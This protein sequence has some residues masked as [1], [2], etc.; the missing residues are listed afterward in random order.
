[1]GYAIWYHLYNFKNVKNIHGG[2]LLKYRVLLPPI[3]EYS[4]I[5]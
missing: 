3:D 2:V 1:M 5:Y 4:D